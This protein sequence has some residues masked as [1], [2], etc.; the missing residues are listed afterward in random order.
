[1]YTQNEIHKTPYIE[2]LVNIVKNIG[3]M[4]DMS[5]CYSKYNSR[6]VWRLRENKSIERKGSFYP[7]SFQMG[8]FLSFSRL[9]LTSTNTWS[10]IYSETVHL[11]C[12]GRAQ[13]TDRGVLGDADKWDLKQTS[14]T[15][16]DMI[17]SIL[18]LIRE[19]KIITKSKCS[20]IENIC[21]RNMKLIIERTFIK[22]RKFCGRFNLHN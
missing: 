15:V 9:N 10:L 14:R 3:F 6:R 5:S 11:L 22:L 12:S 8:R 18:L 21:L 1:M 13:A 2:F 17:L 20:I 16:K 7:S 19:I 4:K